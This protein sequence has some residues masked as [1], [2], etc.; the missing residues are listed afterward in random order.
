ME[1]TGDPA[2]QPTLLAPMSGNYDM[3][4]ATAQ[5]LIVPQPLN[6]VTLA[7]KPLLLAFTAQAAWEVEDL[8]PASLVQETLVDWDDSHPLPFTAAGLTEIARIM[9]S[10]YETSAALGYPTTTLNPSVLMQAALVSDIQTRNLANAAVALWANNDNLD[11]TPQTP[12]YATG[13]LQDQIV[14]FASASYPVP[15]GYFAGKPFF[16]AGNTQNL[17]HSMRARGIGPDSVAWFGLDGAYF[18]LV[19]GDLQR[20]ALNHL[21]GLVPVLVLAARAIETNGFHDMPQL[22]N[23]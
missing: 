14:P 3:T 16:P 21:N 15:P 9:A 8:E 12:I 13:I 17:I 4:G 22:P 11:W 10:L 1:E 6:A 23:P 18:Q 19:S 5:S 2:Y 20:K 7:A